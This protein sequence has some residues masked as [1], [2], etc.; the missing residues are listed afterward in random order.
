MLT[1]RTLLGAALATPLLRAQ[2]DKLRIGITDWNLR[3]TGKPEAV[4]LAAK[5]GFDG[6]QVSC[7]RNLVDGKLP[8]DNPKLIA[9]MK[10]L[11]K[12]HKIPLDGTCLDRL[13]TDG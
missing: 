8:L 11:S 3:L 4:A 7:G 5:L 1:R 6:V 13:H 10:A 9:Q 12:E 2:K